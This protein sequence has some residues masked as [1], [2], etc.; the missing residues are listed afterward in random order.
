MHG[1]AGVLAAEAGAQPLPRLRSDVRLIGRLEGSGYQDDQ[2]L[3]D[4]GGTFIQVPG[5]LYRIIEQLSGDGR[6]A[7]QVAA[8]VSDVSPWAV[9]ADQVEHV[10]RT[11]LR[12]LG[13]LQRDDAPADAEPGPTRPGRSPFRLALKRRLLG[14]RVVEP[15]ARALAWLFHPALIAVVL[16]LAAGMHVWLYAVR[17]ATG[18]VTEIINNPALILVVFVTVVAAALFHE[19]GHAAALSYGGGRVRGMGVGFYVIFPAF[20]TDVTDGYR[21]SRRARVRT[22]LGG[23]YFHLIFALLVAGVAIITRQPFWL[24]VVV[25]IDVEILRQFIPFVRLDGYWL[26]ADLTGIP[27]LFSNI[28]PFVRSIFRRRGSSGDGV[29]ALRPAARLTFLSYLLVAAVILPAMFA[30]AVTR[31]PRLILLAWLSLLGRAHAVAGAWGAGSPVGVAAA[32]VEVGLLGIELL[33][34][35]VFGYLFLARPIWTAWVTTGRQPNQVRRLLRALALL[36]AGGLLMVLGALLPWQVVGSLLFVAMNGVATGWGWL[37]LALGLS[38]IAAAGFMIMSR[39]RVFRIVATAGSLVF[40]TLAIAVSLQQFHHISGQN[41]VA[42]REG[43][44]QAVGR[45]PTQQEMA[46]AERMVQLFGLSVQPWAGLYVCAAGGGLAVIG[47]ITA[48]FGE[49]H[50]GS[51]APGVTRVNDHPDVLTSASNLVK[52]P[53]RAG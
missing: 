42:I 22:D 53:Q 23:P 34:F 21:L 48:A 37:V 52:G 11:K 17:G 29:L 19:W 27:D 33:G 49:R 20:Y 40:A 36:C 15:P 10:V 28:V 44:T 32:T 7:S 51:Q 6:S 26:L 3:I 4:R 9:T 30:V 24:F 38:T 39:R 46:T 1:D 43:I 45:S 16:V 35:A 31:L 47:A 5:L 41:A 12:P 50:R 25:L 13:L 14:P 18:S 8:T 2:W